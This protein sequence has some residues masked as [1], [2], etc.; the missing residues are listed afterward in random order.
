MYKKA[1]VIKQSCVVSYVCPN[2]DRLYKVKLTDFTTGQGKSFEDWTYYYISFTC[3]K[4]GLK[5]TFEV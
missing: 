2:I 5:H 3:P 4:C 1:K